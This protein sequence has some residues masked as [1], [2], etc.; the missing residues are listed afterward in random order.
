DVYLD[1]RF[2][3]EVQN[4]CRLLA[5]KPPEAYAIGKLAIELAADLDRAQGRNVE[6]IAV[7]QIVL[8]DEYKAMLAAV[9][10][11]LTKKKT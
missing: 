3:K 5:Q 10:A 2:D 4:F 6:R 7:S 1:E 9:Q 11:R 8:G